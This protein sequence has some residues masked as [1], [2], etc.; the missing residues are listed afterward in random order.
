MRRMMVAALCAL[1]MTAAAN[2]AIKEEPVTYQ[3]RR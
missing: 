1:A 3:G 2:A